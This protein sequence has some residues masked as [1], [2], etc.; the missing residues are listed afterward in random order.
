MDVTIPEFAES[1]TE[2]DLGRWLKADG[3]FVRKD[4]PLLEIETDKT[5]LEIAAGASGKLSILMAE[6]ETV[7]SGVLVARIAEGEGEAAGAAPTATAAA[8]SPVPSPVSAPVAPA[9][10]RPPVARPAAAASPR[11]GREP[12]PKRADEP[13]TRRVR[14]SRLRRSIAERLVEAQRTAAI[15]TT[16]N[17]VDMSELIALRKQNQDWFVARHGVK[18]GYVS[19]FGKAVTAALAEVPEVNA[20]I[21]GRDVVY[22][23]HVNLGIAVGTEK[24]LV[25]PV[26]RNAE[27]LSLGELE[28]EIQR[29][30]GRAR[31]GDLELAELQGGTF[32]VSNGGIYGSLLSTPILNPPQSGILG[33]HL[34][35]QR[36]R[37][38]PD[39][40]IAARP[41][42][43]VALSYDHR[44]VDGK[45]A[46]TFLVKVKERLEDPE[47]LL[48]SS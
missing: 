4:E 17:E 7:T 25:V 19:L 42:M 47:R 48:L 15:L 45:E 24:G 3:D 1:V 44:I 20:F 31:D 32:T 9:V 34:I 38:M 18:L 41:M 29:L 36:A 5:T 8:P 12:E 27:S 14:M 6:G 43:F 26:V 22:H 11:D 28:K 2:G 46:V 23:D 35:E 13:G 39:G 16:F 21:D 10:S 37:V 40:S 30:A 33:M